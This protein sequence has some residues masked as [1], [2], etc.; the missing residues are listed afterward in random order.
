MRPGPAR[1]VVAALAA[2]FF[3]VPLALIAGGWRAHAFENRPLEPAPTLSEGFNGFDVA[4]RYLIDR[5]PLRDQAVH[6]NTWIDEHVFATTPFYDQNS[7]GGVSSDQAA[8]PFS[9]STAQD[10][11]TVAAAGAGATTTGKQTAQ[12]PAT[13]SQVTVGTHGWYFLQG[14]LQ[15]ACSPFESFS[16]AAAEWERLLAVIRASGRR[17]VLIVAPDKSTIYPEYLSP[18]D[19]LDRCGQIGSDALWAQIESA[20]ARRDGIIGLRKPLEAI[21]R[22]STT[23]LYYKTDS[24]WNNVG[25]LTM[26]Q[27]VL[28]ALSRTVRMRHSEIVDSGYSKYS[29]DLLGLLGQTGSEMAPSVA[30]HR[31]PGAPVIAAPTLVLG[32]SYE[33]AAIPEMAPFFARLRSLNFNEANAAAQAKAIAAAHDV[34]LETVERE[35][36]YRATSV[37]FVAPAFV[38]LVRRTLAAHPLR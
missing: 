38:A 6:A 25:S 22:Q 7:L 20:T 35:F 16:A 13:A 26:A 12:P 21:K 11:A 3:F 14:V 23:L 27:A 4:T 37:G 30:I 15:R 19:S 24:H 17:A 31:A 2:V 5:L 10:R 32:D 8:L 9:G 18:L 28:P 1:L 33:D 36:D 34:V 29:G